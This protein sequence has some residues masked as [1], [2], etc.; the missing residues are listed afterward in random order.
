MSPT[1]E[2]EDVA[3][4]PTF[5]GG[6]Q[7][8]TSQKWANIERLST[9]HFHSDDQR[10]L[11]AQRTPPLTRKER[12]PNKPRRHHLSSIWLLD[13]VAGDDFCTC[14]STSTSSL[15]SC[16]HV[17]P[18]A[19]TDTSRMGRQLAA[20]R[21]VQFH[22]ADAALVPPDQHEH[23]QTASAASV[24][25]LT[26]PSTT[27]GHS[28]APSSRAPSASPRP[29]APGR[30]VRRC[31]PCSTPP[32]SFKHQH[33]QEHRL[34]VL[35]CFSLCVLLSFSQL[36]VSAIPSTKSTASPFS[37]AAAGPPQSARDECEEHKHKQED[38]HLRVVSSRQHEPDDGREAHTHASAG[39]SS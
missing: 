23:R 36:N 38:E 33:E 12:R 7:S 25:V 14:T 39:D 32:Y 4:G 11:G 31:S 34:R 5:G 35:L 2:I 18:K 26:R 16:P 37:P 27:S 9:V 8:R 15:C 20:P 21:T 28:S 17:I 19:Q 22:A 3:K 13:S 1:K 10:L 29:A 30:A 24:H 6:R